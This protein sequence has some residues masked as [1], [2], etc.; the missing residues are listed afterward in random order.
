MLVHLD[1]VGQDLFAVSCYE[2]ADLLLQLLDFLV[3]L[4]NVLTVNEGTEDAIV[5]VLVLRG[6]RILHH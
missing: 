2:L 4:D 3:M 6:G 5:W 1:L